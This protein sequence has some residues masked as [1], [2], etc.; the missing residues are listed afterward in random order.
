M[1]S[2]NKTMTTTTVA[3]ALVPLSASGSGDFTGNAPGRAASPGG[4]ASYE[5]AAHNHKGWGGCIHRSSCAV[6]PGYTVVRPLV[7]MR[8][9]QMTITA[10]TKAVIRLTNQLDW[11]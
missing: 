5:T 3:A 10:P 6:A 9:T 4:A 2:S 8:T 1:T 7:T 11:S